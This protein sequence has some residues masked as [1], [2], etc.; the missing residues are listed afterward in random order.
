MNEHFCISKR[1]F[2]SIA[3][4]YSCVYSFIDTQIFDG[5]G[6]SKKQ[7]VICAAAGILAVTLFVAGCAEQPFADNQ[8]TMG[9][10]ERPDPA[11]IKIPDLNFASTSGD[12][13]DYDEYY[14]FYKH[15]VSY[16]QAFADL[17]QCRLLSL[18]TQLAGVP[19]KFVPLGS[20]KIADRS[21][22]DLSR[23][24]TMYGIAGGITVELI[25]RS[26]EDDNTR[27]NDKRCMAYKGYARYGTT[28]DIW[29]EINAGS[30]S[31]DIARQALIASGPKPS[32][33]AIDP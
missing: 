26:A 25:V 23:A 24:W 10:L 20:D 5:G 7:P 19:P 27:E 3:L 30:D 6:V 31:A 11:T 14:Y 13:G 29:H 16:A 28:S 18:E 1:K 8:K 15:G 32:A 22:T 2:P 4:I 9:P 33:K 12:S 21:R 17:D